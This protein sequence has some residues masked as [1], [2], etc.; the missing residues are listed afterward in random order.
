MPYT[1]TMRRR[2]AVIVMTM[3]VLGLVLAGGAA[4]MAA[5][6]QH[7]AARVYTV[8][9]ALEGLAHA[10]A[11]WNGRTVEVQGRAVIP[12]CAGAAPCRRSLAILSDLHQPGSQIRLTWARVNPLLSMLLQI[13]YLGSAAAGRVGG[14]GIYRVRLIHSTLVVPAANLPAYFPYT[15][16]MVVAYDD[17][18]LLVNGLN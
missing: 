9:Q 14:V 5:V 2:S 7:G 16:R 10:P 1:R 4:T 8:A 17:Q 12:L 13:P 6:G 15:N 11:A 18:A 3:A